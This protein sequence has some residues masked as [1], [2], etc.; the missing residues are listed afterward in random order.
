MMSANVGV[1]LTRCSDSPL[2]TGTPETADELD[3]AGLQAGAT[4]AC[5][6]DSL[7]DL[8]FRSVGRRMSFIRP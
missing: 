3:V 1:F 8:G 7:I 4:L 6:Y 5:G 2:H